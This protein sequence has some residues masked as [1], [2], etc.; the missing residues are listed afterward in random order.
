MKI[1]FLAF[2]I[3]SSFFLINIQAKATPLENKLAFWDK[4]Q[5]GAN[6]F[7]QIITPE[8]IQAAKSYGIA[9]IRLAPDKFQSTERDF[10]IGNADKYTQLVPKDLHTLKKILDLCAKEKMP[11]VLTL[12]SLP[13]SRWKQHNHDQDDLRLWQ[14]PNFQKQTAQFWK[15]LAQ[16]LKD[17]PAIVGYNILNEPHPEKLYEITNQPLYEANQKRVQ[18][19]L[20][21]FY[22]L[23]IKQI[24]SVDKLTPIIVDSS[25]YGDPNTFTFFKPHT[26]PHILYS[27]HMYEPYDFTNRQLNQDQ[28]S[29]PGKIKNTIWN[30]ETLKNYMQAVTQFQR[31][32]H[33]PS[34][35]IL[36]GE[37]GGHRSSAGLSAYFSDLI[38]IFNENQWHFAFYAFR[39][40]TWDGMD[41]ELG[42]K[43]L[44]WE[45]WRALEK[46]KKS[47]LDRNVPHPAF[48]ILINNI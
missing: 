47:K 21:D 46:G 32:H 7:N 4:T 15:D 9:F 34:N 5:K 2:I 41:Y 23:V 10:L 31:N 26:D 33:I 3:L 38:S 43:K 42:D 19:M 16:E 18:Q 29:Y 8:D 39:E 6:I 35:R 17:H 37:F 30:K 25:A 48:D 11:V 44:P 28:Y 12:I 45:Y 40:D 14:D 20:F 36:V 13:G 24:R 22:D 1:K 27:F